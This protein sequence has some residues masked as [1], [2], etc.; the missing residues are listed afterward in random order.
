VLVNLVRLR[1]G[2]EEAYRLYSE[3]VGPLLSRHGAEPVYAGAAAG[4]LIGE[5]RWDLAAVTRYPSREAL[6]A[7][8]RDPEFIA[9]APLRHAALEDGLLYAFA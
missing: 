5:E 2:G 7:L 9:S 1:P 4:V 3:A 6:A 8:V